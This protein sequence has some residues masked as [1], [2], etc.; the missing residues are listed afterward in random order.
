MRTVIS[1]ILFSIISYSLNAQLR[2]T[3][4]VRVGN[5]KKEVKVTNGSYPMQVFTLDNGLTVILNEDNTQKDVLGAV[6]VR[7][8]SKLDKDDCTGIA[9]Y[10]EHLMFKGTKTLGTVNY[11][12]ERPYLDSIATLYDL[13]RLDR[14]N[15]IMRK[16]ILEKIDSFS[17]VASTYAIPNE[18]SKVVGEFGG[19]ENNAYTNFE[20]IV[21]YNRFPSQSFD[22]W[23]SITEDRFREPVFRLFQSELETV[24]EEKNMSMDNMIRRVYQELYKSFYPNSV[25]GKRTVLGSVDDLKNPSINEIKKY[26]KHYYNAKNMAIVLIGNFN[27]NDIIAKLNNHFSSWI[28]GEVAELPMYREKPFN[29]REVVKKK[30]TPIPAGILGFRGVERGNRDEIVLEVALNMLS[31][32]AQTGLLDTLVLKQKL[33]VADAIMDN[34][35]DEGGIFIL[36]VPKPIIQSIGNAEKK[37]ISQIEKLKQGKFDNELL[38]ASKINLYKDVVLDMEN[39]SNRLAQIIDAYMTGGNYQG[40]EMRNKRIMSIQKE[41]IIRVANMYFTKNYLSFQSKMGFKSKEKLSKPITS[42]L[43]LINKNSI[44]KKAFEITN[45]HTEPIAPHFIDFKHDVI[46]EDIRPSLHF[47]YTENPLNDIFSLKIRIAYGTLTDPMTKQL[48]YYLNNAGTNKMTQTEFS[49]QLQLMGSSINFDADNDYFTISIDGF[50]KNLDN[51]LTYLNILLTE[52]KEDKSLNKK[53][54]KD[55]KMEIKML[56]KDLGS[57]ISLLEEYALYGNNSTYLKRLTNKELKNIKYSDIKALLNNIMNYE[58]YVHYVGR[59]GFSEARSLIFKSLPSS[60]G[61]IKSRS[62]IIRPLAVINHNMLYFLEDNNAIQSYIRYD[63]PSRAMGEIG[64]TYI[65]PFNEYFGL[66]M[67]S[68]IFREIREYR[69]LAYSAWGYFSVPYLFSAHSKMKIALSTQADKT[70]YAIE[71]VDSLL[72]LKSINEKSFGS[73]RTS[74]LNSFN[75]YIPSFRK[76][77]YLVQHWTMQGYNSDPRDEYYSKY[78]KLTIKDINNFYQSNVSGRRTI[79]SIVGDSKRF[80]LEKIKVQ[81]EFRKVEFKDIIRY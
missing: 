33:M 30:L 41:D 36:F 3:T 42:P 57:K 73:L 54:L 81:R 46:V 28:E 77:S 69:S 79:M 7:G 19:S 74:V 59:K 47:F 18:F 63:I 20:N 27:S 43:N 71:I 11:K 26:W 44:S 22:K 62:P 48:A 23:L 17:V 38:T 4:D 78:L 35:Y 32:D 25:Y 16:R 45:I 80:D 6:V 65:K 72:S 40:I 76:K 66:G 75:S 10:L 55:N 39:S 5:K 2:I 37:I 61:Q 53:M 67:N 49:K 64:R 15:T 34:H 24:Y 8:G 1:I 70:N 50:E 9:H 29:G 58:T 31:N 12:K 56:K 14:E 60:L 21:Y 68:L 52:F 13:M 51:T